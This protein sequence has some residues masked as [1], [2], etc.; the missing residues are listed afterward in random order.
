MNMLEQAIEGHWGERCP[1]HED[2]CV[3]CKAWEQ[4]DQVVKYEELLTN[5]M[6][7]I[8]KDRDAVRAMTT[9]KAMADAVVVMKHLWLP[10]NPAPKYNLM[11]EEMTRPPKDPEAQKLALKLILERP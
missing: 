7:A 4:Y 5:L 6:I 9:K 8:A 3:V 11:V 10:V 1:D 2:E